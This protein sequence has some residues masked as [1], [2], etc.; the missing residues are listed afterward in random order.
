MCGLLLLLSFKMVAPQRS[1]GEKVPD[2]SLAIQ[3][4]RGALVVAQMAS[5]CVLVVSTAFLFNGF[6][7]ALRS[8]V[9]RRLGNPILATVQVQPAMGVDTNYFQQ[10]EHA[11][12]SVKGVSSIVWV[13]RPPGSPPMWQSFR[14]EPSSMP[15]Q[16]VT[17]DIGWF[18][19]DSLDLFVLPPK[20]GHM[21][22]FTDQGCPNAIVNEQA[23]K[24]LFDGFPVGRAV[25][26]P[27]GQPVQIIGVVATRKAAPPTIYYN[28]S[29]QATPAPDQISSAHFRVAVASP[30]AQR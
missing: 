8:G 24:I 4:F 28:H 25:Q 21:F 15:L 14:V 16:D 20:S 5:C 7:A 3:R 6:H 13:G 27:V 11:A 1:Y 9:G 17:L 19:P 30:L 29:T 18:T 22:G 10:V 2:P 12:R 23:A 26:D